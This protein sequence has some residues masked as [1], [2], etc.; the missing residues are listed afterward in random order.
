MS[1]AQDVLAL[2]REYVEACRVVHAAL[3]NDGGEEHLLK[4]WRS[5]R[6]A[7]SGTLANGLQYRFH[8][9]GCHAEWDG[10]VVD[11]DLGPG[12]KVGGFD[13]QRLS[14]F[15]DHRSEQLGEAE[16]EEGFTMLERGGQINRPGL[17]P[18]PHLYYL[19]DDEVRGR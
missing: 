10:R 18:S 19:S 14:W 16:L 7:E 3:V 2:I 8:G 17:N 11:F 6:L 15:D 13:L 12:G 4:A 1:A 5:G 9:V